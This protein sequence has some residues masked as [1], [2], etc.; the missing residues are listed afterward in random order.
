MLHAR[1][2]APALV[3]TLGLWTAA[4]SGSGVDDTGSTS[5]SIPTPA[6]ERRAWG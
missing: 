3:L 4:C 1:L 5:D 6:T 2:L